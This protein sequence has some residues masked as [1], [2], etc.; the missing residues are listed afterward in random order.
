MEKKLPNALRLANLLESSG[1]G[2]T[3]CAWAAFECGCGASWPEQ[4]CR[5]AA[6]ELRRLQEEVE[7]LNH[8]LEKEE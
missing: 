6:K 4:Y 2:C 8:M 3:C 5:E 1:E 7:F